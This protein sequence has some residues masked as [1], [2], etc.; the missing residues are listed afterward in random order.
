MPDNVMNDA[1]D[2]EPDVWNAGWLWLDANSYSYA[3]ND[4]REQ[5]PFPQPGQKSRRTLKKLTI[6]EIVQNMKADGFIEA[7]GPV[8]KPGHYLVAL[9]VDPRRDFHLM[10]QDSNG[11]WSH[12]PGAREVTNKDWDGRAIVR[13]EKANWGPYAQ[14]VGYFLVPKGGL[15]VGRVEAKPDATPEDAPKP[16]KEQERAPYLPRPQAW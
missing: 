12:K 5:N 14:F 9:A 8:V 1:P 4:K 2:Y 6:A 16:R 15:A 10:R 3:A 7:E 11:R 13:P